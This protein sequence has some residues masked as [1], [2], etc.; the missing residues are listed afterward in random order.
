M[1]YRLCCIFL[2]KVQEVVFVCIYACM[3]MYTFKFRDL[4]I[5]RTCLGLAGTE[6]TVARSAAAGERCLFNVWQ[7]KVTSRA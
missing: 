5:C 7:K 1:D 3:H 4:N 2:S 6:L